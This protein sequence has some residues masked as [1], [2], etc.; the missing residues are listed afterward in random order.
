MVFAY[1]IIIQNIEQNYEWKKNKNKTKNVYGN[2]ISKIK[3]IWKERKKERK[4]MHML[5]IINVKKNVYEK[6]DE[7]KKTNGAKRCPTTT[8]KYNPIMFPSYTHTHNT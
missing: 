5:H 2:L 8:T 6:N 3:H 4:N 7:M 1:G